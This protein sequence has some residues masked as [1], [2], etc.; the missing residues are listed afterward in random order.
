ME[1]L[2]IAQASP[3]APLAALQGDALRRVGPQFDLILISTR[4]HAAAELSALLAAA[5]PAGPRAPRRLVHLAASESALGDL[6]QV[7]RPATEVVP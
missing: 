4:E 6:F 3:A 1:A 5:T 7:D 2:A